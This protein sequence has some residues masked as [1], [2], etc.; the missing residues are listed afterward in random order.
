VKALRSI[1][2]LALATACFWVAG[3]LYLREAGR[4]GAAPLREAAPRPGDPPLVGFASTALGG[5]RGLV[6]DLLWVRA[7]TLQ[8]EG[9]FFEMVQL[10]D[11]ITRLEPRSAEVWGFHAWNI[12]YNVSAMFPSPADRWRWVRNGIRLL[13]DEALPHNPRDSRLHWELGWLYADKIGGPWDD[14]ERFY[15]L[16]LAAEMEQAFGGPLPAYRRL[17]DDRRL[18]D[19]LREQEGL[20][21]GLMSEMDGLYGPLDWRLPESVAAYW[22]QQG[23]RAGGGGDDLWCERLLL[24]ALAASVERGALHFDAAR[25]VYVRGPRFDLLPA[26]CRAFDAGRAAHP[27]DPVIAEGH[28]RF[29]AAATVLCRAFGRRAEAEWLVEWLGRA[30]PA[31]AAGHNLD[32]VVR[33]EVAARLEGTDAAQALRQVE[34]LSAQAWAWLGVGDAR[35]AAGFAAYA[36]MLWEA[37]AARAGVAVEPFEEVQRRALARVLGTLPDPYR[38]RLAERALGEGPAPGG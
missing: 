34:S 36:R 16:Q 20:D 25:Q 22:A 7:A 31:E 33:E 10:A 5:F 3:R 27:R 18:A 29:V 26:A 37:A 9:R 4:V 2:L 21:A 38:A 14:A 8:E 35:Q 24:H 15:K 19:R 12:A 32:A 28:R 23:R 13:R 17:A 11:W 6:A 1:L 30:N